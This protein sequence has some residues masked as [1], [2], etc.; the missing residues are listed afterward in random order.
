LK[1]LR[2]FTLGIVL[3]LSALF[4]MRAFAADPPSTT[5]SF[6][7]WYVLSVADSTDAAYTAA[8]GAT[9]VI[10]RL[11]GVIMVDGVP[12]SN[13]KYATL[14][15]FKPSLLPDYDGVRSCAEKAMHV[16]ATQVQT[17]PNGYGPGALLVV[18]A[19]GDIRLNEGNGGYEGD[20]NLTIIEVR[21]LKSIA[22][23]IQ[24]Q[25]PSHP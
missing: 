1:H 18:K 25:Y 3:V 14:K 16:G 24:F 13:A 10:G 11:N 2:T 20:P 17:G 9:Y 23:E 19:T 15:F 22:C 8:F 7:Y 21:S 6:M 12:N 5:V 4:P